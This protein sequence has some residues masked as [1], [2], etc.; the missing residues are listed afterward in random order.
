MESNRS[1]DEQSQFSG[2]GAFV[3]GLVGGL[4]IG[5]VDLPYHHLLNKDTE[6]M[7]D[8]K[9]KDVVGTMQDN[10]KQVAEHSKMYRGMMSGK[11]RAITGAAAIT[12]GA[13][14]GGMIGH[15]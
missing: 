5:A 14:F 4:K 12:A 7:K 1:A 15:D 10:H 6:K 9:W 8:G 2:K 11:G 13:I 3:G